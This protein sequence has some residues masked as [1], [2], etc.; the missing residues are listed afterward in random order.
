MEQDMPDNIKDITRDDGPVGEEGSGPITDP[1]QVEKNGTGD[2]AESFEEETRQQLNILREK[3]FTPE[4]RRLVERVRDNEPADDDEYIEEADASLNDEELQVRLGRLYYQ[5]SNILDDR[6]INISFNPFDLKETLAAPNIRSAL[7]EHIITQMAGLSLPSFALL[8]YSMDKKGFVPAEHNLSL[9]LADNI[10]V[11]LRDTFFKRI[12]ASSDG[13]IFD[14]SEL[15]QDPCLSKIFSPK[16]G[17]AVRPIYFI[18]LSAL[19]SA[20]TGEL[21]ISSRMHLSPFLPSSMLMIELP[22]RSEY[23]DAGAITAAIRQKLSIP[24]FL[25]NDNL[26]LIFSSGTYDDLSYTYRVLDYLFTIFLLQRD[27]AGLSIQSKTAENSNM[28]FLIKYIISKLSHDLYSDS[29]IVHI[30]RNRLLILT[31]DDS[32]VAIKEIINGYNDLI[33]G[34]FSILEFY[35]ADFQDSLDIIQRIIIDN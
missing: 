1:E 12:L 30:L 4:L 20:V 8:S 25:L 21:L 26:S 10:I 11:S 9:Y 31:R 35:P 33:K 16:D 5:A 28:S 6:G 7:V 15:G 24:Y 29:A 32:M 34:Q 23:R 3:T 17:T 13:I 27:R 19:V 22:A 2:P 18:Q 14:P